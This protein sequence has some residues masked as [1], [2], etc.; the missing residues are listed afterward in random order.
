MTKLKNNPVADILEEEYIES[1]PSFD[2]ADTEEILNI[3]GIFNNA[4]LELTKLTLKYDKSTQTKKG[5]HS[6]YRGSLKMD[7]TSLAPPSCQHKH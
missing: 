2:Y 1:A 7:M 3:L 6:A 4:A 5:V